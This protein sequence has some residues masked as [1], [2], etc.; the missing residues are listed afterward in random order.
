MASLGDI[1]RVVAGLKFNA[2]GDVQNVFHLLVSGPLPVSDADLVDDMGEHL[3]D[4]YSLNNANRA[5]NITFDLYNVVNLT[6][7]LE[8]GEH[9]WPSLTAGLGG[10]EALPPGDALLT[11][12][13]T[14]KSRVQGRNYSGCWT[15]GN[16]ADGQWSTTFLTAMATLPGLIWD[17][18]TTSLGNDYTPIIYNRTLGTFELPVEYSIVPQT[19]YQRRRRPGSGS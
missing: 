7:D 4:I 16:N 1:I 8:L 6:A 15:E 3:E 5:N 13:R 12:A 9:P 2:T 19:S 17:A 10:G 14:G 11:L 18:F